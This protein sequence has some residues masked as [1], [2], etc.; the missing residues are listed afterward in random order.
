MEMQKQDLEAGQP[1]GQSVKL[2]RRGQ[3]AIITLNRP[4]EL[5]AFNY[6]TLMRLGGI[7]EEIRQDRQRIRAVIVTGAG[8]AFS[9]GADLKERRVLNEEQVRR[10]V[11]AIRDVFAAV[12]ELP[13]P[14]IAAVN[15]YAFGGGFELMLACDFRFAVRDARMGLT[16]VSLGIIPG[17]GGTQRLPRLIGPAR[18]KELILTARKIGAEEALQYGLLTGIADDAEQLL[19]AALELANEIAANAPLAVY[20]AKYA[21]NRG[22]SVD[23]HSGLEV[24]AQAYEMIIPT[25]DRAEALAA[26]ADKRKPVFRGE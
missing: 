4:G 24:E 7:V 6:E 15:G 20:Q 5:N 18:A 25:K 22:A 11:R 9:A 21:I 17:A 23:L 1:L 2:E 19:Q 26:F 10:N 14:T 13:Q 12:E 3:A 16:E 8:R